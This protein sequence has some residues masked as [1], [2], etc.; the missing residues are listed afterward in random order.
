[1]VHWDR[2]LTDNRLITAA[3]RDA[4]FTADKNNYGYGWFVRQIHGRPAQYHSGSDNGFS[5]YFVRFP[6]DR[7]T[8]V[9]LSNSDRTNAGRVG[10]DLAAIAFGAPYKLP[11]EQLGDLLWNVM[12]DHGVEVALARYAELKRTVP[13]AYDFDDE[14]LVRMGYDLFEVRRLA[15]AGAVFEYNLKLYPKSAYSYDGLAD[16]AKAKGDTAT[17][18]AMFEKSLW[19]DPEN[20]YAIEA[21]ARLRADSITK[22]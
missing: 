18:I 6:A 3:S 11:V 12:R 9:V 20:R 7:I 15:E 13:T 8:V 1:M 5:S 10:N 14:T 21:L 4:M 22:L 2:A 17:A 16:I 19:A